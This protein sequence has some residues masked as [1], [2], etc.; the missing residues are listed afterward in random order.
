MLVTIF[1]YSFWWNVHRPNVCSA[2]CLSAKCR[3]PNVVGQLP[4]HAFLMFKVFAFSILYQS[5]SES[6]LKHILFILKM[7]EVITFIAWVHVLA[8]MFLILLP[9]LTEYT[10]KGPLAIGQRGWLIDDAQFYLKI[11]GHTMTLQKRGI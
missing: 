5:L 11:L 7:K 8:I 10:V 6:K 9:T 3:R 2:K 1:T 4:D